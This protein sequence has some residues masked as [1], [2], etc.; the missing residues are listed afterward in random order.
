MRRDLRVRYH[1]YL[2]REDW[3]CSRRPLYRQAG[4]TYLDCHHV[5]LSISLE[6]VLIQIL[7]R[8]WFAGLMGMLL[9]S[10]RVRRFL[11]MIVGRHEDSREPASYAFSFNPIPGLVIAVVSMHFQTHPVQASSFTA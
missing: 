10:R 6:N 3:C 4:P 1:E 11:A 5:S 7:Y 2:A 8:F 9:E